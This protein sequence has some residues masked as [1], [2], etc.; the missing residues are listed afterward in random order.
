MWDNGGNDNY[1]ASMHAS[2]GLGH[3]FG[4]GFLLDDSGNDV[5]QA[6]GL[7]VGAGNQNGFGFFWDKAGDDSY[8]GVSGTTSAFG[9]GIFDVNFRNSI[10]EQNLVLGVF[11]DTGGNDTYPTAATRAQNNTLWQV[12]RDDKMLP[13]QRGVGLDIEA[14]PAANVTAPAQP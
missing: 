9:A 4:T 7:S 1:T 8:A 5:Y 10:R 13:I 2:Q 6:P 3:D 12:P 11:L 14:T